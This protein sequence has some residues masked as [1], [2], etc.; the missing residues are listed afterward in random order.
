MISSSKKTL[1]R[2]LCLAENEFGIEQ[3]RLYHVESN[4]GIVRILFFLLLFFLLFKDP[5]IILIIILLTTIILILISCLIVVYCCCRVRRIRRNLTMKTLPIVYDEHYSINDLIKEVGSLKTCHTDQV[6]LKNDDR[7]LTNLFI[8]N[9]KN[10]LDNLSN[11]SSTNSSGFH[12]KIDM[13]SSTISPI[14]TG[15]IM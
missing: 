1:N 9:T 5:S 11:Q 7:L 3:S 2:L 8:K 12:S 15:Q 6:S 4:D 13:R 14:Y 10:L